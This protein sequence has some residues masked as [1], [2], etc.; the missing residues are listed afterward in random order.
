LQAREGNETMV[1]GFVAVSLALV[2]GSVAAMNLVNR[3]A[4][5]IGP[6]PGDHVAVAAAAPGFAWDA[7]ARLPSG[8]DCQI[9]LGQDAGA[10]GE[11]YVVSRGPDG[12][13]SAIWSSKGRSSA[14]GPD[15]GNG[16]AVDLDRVTFSQLAVAAHGSNPGIPMDNSVAF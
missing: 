3:I 7:T 11:L 5:D 2:V 10:G 14:A 15:C 16:A 9:G 4:I 1:L 12:E 8:R 6:A 13:I